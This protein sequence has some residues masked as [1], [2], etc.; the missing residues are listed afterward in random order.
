MLARPFHIHLFVDARPLAAV[1]AHV[2]ALFVVFAQP[3]ASLAWLGGAHATLEQAAV[4]Q[5][6]VE[7]GH[8]HHHHGALVQ[9]EQHRPADRNEAEIHFPRS[10]PGLEIASAAPYSGPSQDLLQTLLQAM[11]AVLP[12]VPSPG[13][14]SRH[15]SP[16]EDLSSQHSPLVPH[17]PPILLLPTLA[18][19]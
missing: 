1:S 17:R 7:Q 18:L 13:E 3:V 9:H 11:F 15:A 4:H 2:L 8:D 10:T 16:M 19:V 6:A 5:A 12:E 14:G